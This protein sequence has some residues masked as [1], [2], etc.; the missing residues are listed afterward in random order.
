MG[1]AVREI[2]HVE[3]FVRDVDAATRW[4]QETLG[5]GPVRRWD[6]EPLMIGAGGAMLALFRLQQT[7]RPAAAIRPGVGAVWRGG[8]TRRGS[9]AAQEHLRARGVTFNGP[10]DHD[11]SE[12]IYFGDPDGNTLEITWN[13]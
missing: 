7:D 9:S 4:Y 8:R 2:D 12:S 1:F 5:L 3:V 6:P 11:T 13:R 10:V